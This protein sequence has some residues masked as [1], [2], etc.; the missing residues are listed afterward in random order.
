MENIIQL[1]QAKQENNEHYKKV[2]IFNISLTEI[3]NHPK[4]TL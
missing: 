3:R 1:S 2:M 4:N